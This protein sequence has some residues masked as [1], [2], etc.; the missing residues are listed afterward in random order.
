MNPDL[1]Q[2]PSA[3][4][5]LSCLAPSVEPPVAASPPFLH[6]TLY[7]ERKGSI[8]VIIETIKH[9]EGLAGVSCLS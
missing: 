4:F 5:P 8:E 1:A 3:L 2:Q 6:H 9:T 7:L